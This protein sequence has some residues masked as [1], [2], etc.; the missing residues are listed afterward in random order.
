M[1]LPNACGSCHAHRPQW[2][3]AIIEEKLGRER[4]WTPALALY[5]AERGTED[6]PQKLLELFSAKSASN[7]VRASALKRWADLGRSTPELSNTILA[8]TKDE[9]ELVRRAA[10]EAV[11]SLAEEARIEALI[12]LFSDKSRSVRVA[13]ALASLEAPAPNKPVDAMQTA[14]SEAKVAAKFRS[15]DADGLLAW[16]ALEEKLGN[17]QEQLRLLEL[18]IARFPKHPQTFSS[19]AA[20]LQRAGQIDKAQ[21]IVLRG[22]MLHPRDSLLLFAR[23]RHLVRLKKAR[24]ALR[25]LHDAFETAPRSRRREYGYVYAVTT[26]ELGDWAEALSILRLLKREYPEA[27]EVQEALTIYEEK[28]T[29]R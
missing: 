6:A 8:A 5:A 19:F 9:S 2:A 3:A 14:L 18:A 21:E 16:A 26:Y 15:D 12:P 4:G 29:T 1:G 11:P 17:P 28:R 27:R 23:G 20:A 13:A 22:L 25:L 10:A 7:I 24:D